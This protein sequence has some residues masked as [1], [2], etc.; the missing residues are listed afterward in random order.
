M[1]K[2]CLLIIAALIV[3]MPVTL[4]QKVE[5]IKY[6]KITPLKEKYLPTGA[7]NFFDGNFS[8]CFGVKNDT[9]GFDILGYLEGYYIYRIGFFVGTW[10][11]SNSLVAGDIIGFF[12][13]RFII[14]WISTGLNHIIQIG[15]GVPLIG[16]CQIN[17]T[18]NELEA[19]AIR[20]QKP[21]IQICWQFCEFEE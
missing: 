5:P 14:G 11:A 15:A 21:P 8:G 10:N 20:I 12:N 2:I 4:S 3:S 1:K 6:S 18:T 13:N 16:R 7:P 17:T 9:K 19:S